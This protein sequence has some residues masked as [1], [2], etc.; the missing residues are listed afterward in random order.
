MRALA[1]NSF[2]INNLSESEDTLTLEKALAGKSSVINVG[3]AGTA[4]RFSTA[5]FA[6]QEGEWIITGSERMKNRPIGELVDALN[7]LGADIKYLEKKGYPPLKIKGKKLTG[8]KIEIDGSIS[9]QFIT[10]LL[11]IAPA[12]EHGLE[13]VL[14]NKI[15]SASY[16]R[17]TLNL[18]KYMGKDCKWEN[19][20][21]TVPAGL[22]QG[23][24]ITVEADWSGA[25]YWYEIVALA[26]KANLMVH[27]LQE[28]SLQGDAAI[29]GLFERTGIQTIYLEN[30]I[31][32]VKSTTTCNFFEH[33]FLDNPDM[34]QTFA[35]VMVLKNI[36]FKF[37][38]TQSL[39]IKET[40]RIAAL[41][42]E[43][44]KFG[45]N[46][47]YSEDGILSWDG[48]KEQPIR[49]IKSI[50]TYQDHRMALAFSPVAMVEKSIIIQEP[51]VVIKSYPN[52]WEDLKKVG[53]TVS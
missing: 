40:D 9:S 53:F 36:P 14:K 17:L 6:L 50:P 24:D 35:V 37:Y 46:L 32:L 8:N 4:M 18:M 52:F 13:I 34:V 2:Q 15:I 49:G 20:I 41:Q 39:R 7:L 30:K 27:G 3:H 33:D 38:G 26:D 28:N 1:N 43:M 21:I 23:K 48:I 25:S 45:A 31:N 29:A 16:I 11:L 42:N 19:N 5:F 12:T 51:G 10:A 44:K 47:T 22:Y